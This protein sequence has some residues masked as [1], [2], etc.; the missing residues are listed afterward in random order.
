MSTDID[1]MV[2]RTTPES[3]SEMQLMTPT[4]DRKDLPGGQDPDTGKLQMKKQL[5]LMEGVA[6]ILGIIFGSGKLRQF[7]RIFCS[8]VIIVFEFIHSS[9][10]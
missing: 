9:L 8:V 1:K 3:P 6:I 10:V 4:E 5:G 7:E 2:Q